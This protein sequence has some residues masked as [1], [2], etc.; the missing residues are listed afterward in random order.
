MHKVNLNEQI[1]VE[2]D[3]FYIEIKISGIAKG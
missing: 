2:L 3:K 1:F